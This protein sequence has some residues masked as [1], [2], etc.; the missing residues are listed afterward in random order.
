MTKTSSKTN[1]RI[2]SAMLAIKSRAID[3]EFDLRVEGKNQL[4]KKLGKAIDKLDGVI[5]TLRGRVLDDWSAKVH[6]LRKELASMNAEVQEAIDDI[7]DKI[8][9]ARNV[10]KLVGKVDEVVDLLG[11]LLI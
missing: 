8:D 1:R 9:T 6:D 4:A 10:V 2:L 5:Q 7:E 3:L 11:P